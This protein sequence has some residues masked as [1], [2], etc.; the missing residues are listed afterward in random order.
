[1]LGDNFGQ[2]PGGTPEAGDRHFFTHTLLPWLVRIEQECNR[3]LLPPG[4][5]FYAEHLPEMLLR[6][7]PIEKA[8]NYKALF[9][10]GVIDAAYIAK[11]ENLPAP[12]AP[13]VAPPPA[14][15]PAPG[16]PW[17]SAFRALIVDV[18]DRFVRR[19]ADRARRASKKGP[20]EFAAWAESFYAAEAGSL[21][22]RLTP[23]VGIVTLRAGLSAASIEDA[24][25][26]IASEH[27]ERSREELLDL[28]KDDLEGQVE[29]LT[30][31]WEKHRP[32]E[33]ADRIAALDA[34]EGEGNAA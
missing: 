19:E 33:M 4:G 30:K 26:A 34:A 31:R 28:R 24:A 5:S 23:V 9:D 25:R 1:M 13:P 6:M 14:T 10:M 16:A 2:W 3:K 8:Q 20:E 11:K 32:A 21:A 27:V 29:R 7:A 15:P 18:A 17:R 12:K 22:E